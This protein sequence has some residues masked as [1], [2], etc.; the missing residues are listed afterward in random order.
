MNS[1]YRFV[2][3]WKDLVIKVYGDHPLAAALVTILAIGAFYILEKTWRP[4]KRPTNLFITLGGWAVAVPILG[5]LLDTVGKI[6]EFLEGLLSI[7]LKLVESSY[8]IYAHHP[9]LILTLVVIAVFGYFALKRWRPA[10]LPGRPAKLIALFVATVVA[11][12]IL[13][14]IADIIAPYSEATAVNEKKS[15]PV[16]ATAPP[17][18]LPSTD[19]GQSFSPQVTAPTKSGGS[20]SIAPPSPATKGPNKENSSSH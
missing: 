8:R 7:V 18:N 11:A 20:Q 3:G 4:G 16:V 5:I 12:H 14:P 2:L 10:I 17:A 15:E 9:F 1:V 6:F 13:A 19:V